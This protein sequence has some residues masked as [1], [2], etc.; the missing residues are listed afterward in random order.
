MKNRRKL[1]AYVA[2]LGAALAFTVLP[3]I[4]RSQSASMSS[5]TSA[6]SSQSAQNIDDATL[7]HVA[8]AYVAVRH[9]TDDTKQ[10]LA[11]TEDDSQKKEISSQAE[12]Q[13]LNI[14]KQEGM[15]PETYNKV[16]IMVQNDP[17]LQQK[18]LS[19]VNSSGGV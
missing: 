8:K 4:A 10:R 14:V 13:K 11:R 6:E 1:N 12:A 3:G 5:D 17:G 18:F 7:Q 15:Q 9:I 2:G 16:L 19:Y